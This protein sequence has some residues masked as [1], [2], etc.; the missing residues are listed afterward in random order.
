MKP[1][2]VKIILLFVCMPVA[3]SCSKSSNSSSSTC[4]ATTGDVSPLSA[5]QQVSYGAT[6]TSGATISTVTYQD[7]AGMT[8]VKNPTL[9]FAKSVNLK[10]GTLVSITASGTAN[11]GE[12]NVTSSGNS[13]NT[14]SC[15]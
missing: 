12:I 1:A 9:P 11:T 7:S 10:S 14:A 3:F 13:F 4:T 8:T 2:Y 15:P 5:N 6:A